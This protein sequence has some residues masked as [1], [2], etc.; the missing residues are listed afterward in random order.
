MAAWRVTTIRRHFAPLPHS[1]RDRRPHHQDRL[2]R[3]Q[4]MFLG[5]RH[6]VAAPIAIAGGPARAGIDAVAAIRAV[7]MPQAKGLM[8]GRNVIEQDD[9]RATLRLL[10]GIVAATE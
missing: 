10:R 6:A 7:S 4:G 1:R 2:V 5:H 9:M 8:F 3:R